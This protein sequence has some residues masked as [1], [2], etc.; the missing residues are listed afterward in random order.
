MMEEG[1]MDFTSYDD[2]NDEKNKIIITHLKND[3]K[4]DS[5]TCGNSSRFEP[6]FP[7]VCRRVGVLQRRKK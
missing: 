7:L 2:D 5:V 6:P 4:F 1:S 3:G